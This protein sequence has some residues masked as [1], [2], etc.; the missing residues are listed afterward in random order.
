M[1]SFLGPIFTGF[2]FKNRTTSVISS[3]LIIAAALFAWHT[4]DKGSALRAAVSEYVAKVELETARSEIEEMKRRA[5]VAEEANMRL[6]ERV[7]AAQGEVIRA[8]REMQAYEAENSI[9]K[10]GLVE[11]DLFDLLRGN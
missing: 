2:L 7:Q 1:I 9:P 6:N 11:P 5:I 10:S 3:V 4:L 8:E